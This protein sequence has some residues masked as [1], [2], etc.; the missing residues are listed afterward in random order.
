MKIPILH[1]VLFFGEVFAHNYFELVVG[2]VSVRVTIL[3]GLIVT[4]PHFFV[5]VVF[6][7]FL[8][9]LGELGRINSLEHDVLGWWHHLFLCSLFLKLGC[10][11]GHS[12]GDGSGSDR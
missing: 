4:L 9:L 1:L 3:A 6:K 12:P 8:D 2:P 10:V 5:G 7:L 11:L